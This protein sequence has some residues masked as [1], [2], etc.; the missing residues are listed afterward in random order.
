M[1]SALKGL[2]VLGLIG[3]FLLIWAIRQQAASSATAFAP[4]ISSTKTA[5]LVGGTDVNGNGF[6]N[7]G[8][9]LQYT[10]VVSNTGAGATDATGTVITDQLNA[11]L[12]LVGNAIASPIAQN[13]SYS[14]IGNVGITINAASGVLV[15]DINPQ[16]TGTIS[17]T[18]VPAGTS[19]QGGSYS[20]LSD[21]SFT[22]N[23]PVGFE[24]TDTFT[25]TLTHSNGLS[26]TGT[27]SITIGGMIWFVDNNSSCSS[28]CNGRLSNPFKTL[29]AFNTAN[30]LSGGLNPD[31]NDNIFIY[32]SGTLY[33][34]AITLR[35]G[36]KLIGQD[37]TAPLAGPGSVTGIT[38]IPP[39]SNSLPTMSSGNATVTDIGSTVTINTNATVRGL[40]IDS[41]T[42][43]GMND[44]AAAITG[45][46]VSEVK[47]ASTTGTAV[48]LSDVGGTLSFTSI[49]A[50]GGANGIS[51]TNTTGSF[52]VTGVGAI[53]GSGGIIQG[54]VGADGASAGHG[55]YM[56]GV[57]NISLSNVTLQ[58]FQGDAIHGNNVSGFTLKG[59]TVTASAGTFNGTTTAQLGNFQGEGG[60]Q[61]VGLTGSA[62]FDQ[63]SIDR[64]FYNSVSV[65]NITSATLN[66]FVFTNNTVGT[67]S[68][69]GNDALVLQQFGGTLNSTI[70]GNT[71]TNAAGDIF[72]L[73]M[74]NTLSADLVFTGNAISNNHPAI[75]SGGG[76]ITIGSGGPSDNITFTFN[77]ANNTM[78]GALGAAL[79]MSSGQGNLGGGT[80][81]GTI[82]ENTI[83]VAGTAN[84]GSMQGQ[85][86]GIINFG[87]V[88]NINITNN[89]LYQ[90]NPSAT[91]ALTLQLGD[92]N[93]HSAFL[94]STITGNTISN[95]G[96]GVASMNGIHLNSG[97]TT[98][99][100]SKACLTIGGAGSLANN[101]SASGANGGSAIRLR[102]RQN[103]NISL[104]GYG[105]SSSDITAVNSFVA[106]NN[107]G[108]STTSIVTNSPPHG[109]F[110]SCPPP[111]N[112][113]D[114]ITTTVERTADRVSFG[115]TFEDPVRDVSKATTSQFNPVA[116]V[117]IQLV[118]GIRQLTETL[119]PTV[120][121]QEV[122][123]DGTRGRPR[124]PESGELIT[125]NG[126]GG[127]FLLP[128][129]KSV[130]V[131][132]NATINAAFAGTSISNQANVTAAGGVNVNSN[133]LS[134]PVIQAPS[135]TKS[136]APGNIAL[137]GTN[138]T[139]STLT[140]TLANPNIS[141]QLTGV[142][143]SDPLVGM[144]VD[145]SPGATTT[146][147]GSPTFAPAANATSLTF[148]A[149]TINVGTPCVVTVKVKGTSLGAKTNTAG[150]ATSTQANT[151][152][153]SNTATLNVLAAPTLTKAF[154]AASVAVGGTTSLTFTITNNDATFGLTG[155]GFTDTLPGGLTV[156]GTPN[157]QGTCG[158]GTITAASNAGVIGLNGASLAAS[159][160][161]SFSVDVT[162]TTAGAKANS[163]ALQT[164]ETGTN[165]SSA[166]ATLNV[167]GPPTFSKNFGTSSIV[168]GQTSLQNVV[169]TN[170]ASNPGS[171]TGIAFTD[172]LPAGITVASGSASSC[173]TGTVTTTA[174]STVTLSAGS[175]ASGASCTVTVTVTG[176]QASVSPWTNTIASVTT[177]NGG[178][179]SIPA[180]ANITVNRASTTTTITSVAPNPSFA[181][182]AI[183]VTYTVN[184]V[185]P[186]AGT[187]TGTVTVSDGVDS[188]SA[189]V[190]AGQ[191]TLNLTTQGARTLTATY[192]G[193]TNFNSS[194]S[195]GTSHQVDP[196][197]T[198]NP[199]V[200][201]LNDSGAGSLR[202]AVRTVCANDTVTFQTGL[203]GTIL[204]STG[205]MSIIRGMTITGPGANV[206]TVSGGS[207]SRIF[208]I[209]AGVWTVSLS[210]L[211]LSNGSPVGS[212]DGG[213]AVLIKNGSAVGPVNITACLITNNN[214]TASTSPVGGGID[215]EGGVV[216]ITGS[217]IANNTASL[218]G[219][220]IQ[221]QGFGSMTI[222]SS[223]ISDNT[224]GAS[225]TGGGV[226]SLLP[227]ML[228]STTIFANSAQNA[229]NVSS[230]TG[231]FGNTIIAGGILVGAG[232]TSPDLSGTL[233][234]LDY[235][236][237][238]NTTG[239][240]VTGATS[241]NITGTSPLVGPL[242]NNGGPTPTRALLSG[243]PARDQGSAFGL[244]TDQRGRARTVDL[245]N[246]ANASDGTDIGAYEIQQTTAA[247]V[248]I[249][250]RVL[251]GSGRAL[252][253]T[254]VVLTDVHGSS[255]QVL[256]GSL[257]TFHF[258]NVEVG[259]TYILTVNTQR[260]RFTPRALQVL[261]DLTDVI[262]IASE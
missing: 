257:G 55:V 126:T 241:H 12:T 112:V 259:G 248:S 151:G 249:S 134:T 237:I 125:I 81:N 104:P 252:R 209:S 233:D 66:R 95:P 107:G 155:I 136:F 140:L 146:G 175:L 130:A 238:E 103:T 14:A 193:D 261:D 202:Q 224:A 119:I 127:G 29:T 258:E 214:V 190:G 139:S 73:D 98:G 45:V 87:A 42:S 83:G 74:H 52:V 27:V 69:S 1:S 143:F 47:V 59:S 88:M 105:G 60:I 124:S 247:G 28:N 23:P 34:G 157:V 192:A 148:T 158:G 188:C 178:T 176:A 109:F 191:C 86:L 82:S 203:T 75:V 162:G 129:G 18:A 230:T 137:T 99:D 13:D 177:A 171:L 64:S 226:R 93:G 262:L 38:P 174:P 108:A 77:I 154:G 7:P 16:G 225:G 215:N 70:T 49:S 62:L 6:I 118:K 205:E 33:S 5:S 96:T 145:T 240:T 30:A 144:A 101:L 251:A 85:D 84:S 229:G 56:N 160:T 223:T 219:G 186:G 91:G 35:T 37:A 19:V 194:A 24:G 153:N 179:N 216:T 68:N 172:I 245:S 100:A 50:N 114:A 21:G 9:T 46:N 163:V 217:T 147:C 180:S 123:R 201:N 8:D 165:T 128:A 132:F 159:G 71:F 122:T 115:S 255:R 67:Q 80:W 44:P 211:T 181:G 254:T 185:A 170:P 166:T 228:T 250:G 63:N 200:T 43:T 90:Y 11:N 195:S 32:E 40:N 256:T 138:Q 121:A 141:Q 199:I 243:S 204:L 48:S 106:G 208:N 232:G 156:A 133:N 184:P 54:M 244:L 61:F 213:G 260:Y 117:W 196:P 161:C 4:S 10:V 2:H 94:T 173:N 210:G 58:N 111:T 76:G 236:L 221:N 3:L 51:L 57:S 253:S 131:K 152:S 218:S 31:N 239:A 135:I 220:G 206:V 242:G 39:F 79:G 41:T 207:L 182:E 142:A 17:V 25:Y 78:R 26:D 22:Y 189:M 97:P 150:G 198:P 89:Q 53:G 246:T 120:S 36:Q 231:S 20:L 234:S 227:L 235:N 187:P 72:Q 168:V 116:A 110:G 164:S 183:L 102:Q 212:S 15:N 169:I 149:G 222:V 197:C 92:D 167:F 65:F 113:P